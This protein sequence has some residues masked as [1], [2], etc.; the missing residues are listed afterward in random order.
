MNIKLNLN[1]PFTKQEFSTNNNL[2]S[3]TNNTIKIHGSN[4]NLPRGNYESRLKITLADNRTFTII[5]LIKW[6]IV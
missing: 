1:H 6:T 2:I 4:I 5:K 3:I